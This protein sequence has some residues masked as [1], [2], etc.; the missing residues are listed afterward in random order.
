[1]QLN[2]YQEKAHGTSRNTEINGSKLTYPLFG[3]AGEMPRQ[4][5]WQAPLSEQV[6]APV[7]QPGQD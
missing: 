5:E 3:I 7:V 4:P 6:Q 2:E 1:M